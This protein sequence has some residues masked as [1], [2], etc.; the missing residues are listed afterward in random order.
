MLKMSDEM[1]EKIIRMFFVVEEDYYDDS[2]LKTFDRWIDSKLKGLMEK[3]K[4]W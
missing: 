3:M 2:K 1:K 4:I